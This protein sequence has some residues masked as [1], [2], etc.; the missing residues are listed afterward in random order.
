MAEI[1]ITGKQIGQLDALAAID[2]SEKIPVETADGNGHLTTQ[3]MREYAQP[4][5]SGYAKKSE[6]AEVKGSA[7]KSIMFSPG[8]AGNGMGV[9]VVRTDGSSD[10]DEAEIPLATTE[11]C[12]MMDANDKINL[13][14]ARTEIQQSKEDILNLEDDIA[15][16]LDA[17]ERLYI[18][19]AMRIKKSAGLAL[20]A[21]IG[22]DNG[23]AETL[24]IQF[25]QNDSTPAWRRLTNYM[26]AKTISC[27]Q[28]ATDL[29]LIVSDGGYTSLSVLMR[30]NEALECEKCYMGEIPAGAT[31]VAEIPSFEDF[32]TE[33]EADGKYATKEEIEGIGGVGAKGTG[34]N[35]EVFNSY[36]SNKATGSCSHAEGDRTKASGAYSHAEG[37]QTEATEYAAHSEGDRTKASGAYSHAEGAFTE[38]GEMYS[39]AEG[40]GTLVTNKSEHAEGSYNLSN[41]GD[42]NAEKTRHSVGI[43]RD[44]EGTT[45]KNA[46]EIMANG[47]AYLYGVGGYD[48]TNA[49]SE[50]AKTLQQVVGGIPDTSQLATKEELGQAVAGK[51]GGTGVSAIEVV[52]E[53]PA[54]PQ[55]GVMYVVMG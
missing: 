10:Y 36:T 31:D 18:S 35:A 46:W 3:Q 8:P 17:P 20:L 22:D 48:G 54:E 19:E 42:T 15:K 13:E 7:V 1:E 23:L 27:K 47:D 50:Q 51:V 4:D 53:L 52:T 21:A 39:H 16:K 32:I 29:Y 12:G 41:T 24:A 28:D 14:T 33:T 34:T 55:D 37:C 43:G 25:A 6:V 11:K 9:A 40:I 44:Y 49:L 2:G 38:A 45:R 30:G 5:L 26:P